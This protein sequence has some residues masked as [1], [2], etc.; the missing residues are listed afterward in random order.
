[1]FRVPF[2]SSP[3]GVDTRGAAPY[4][5][6]RPKQPTGEAPPV[7]RN[8]AQARNR[9]FAR[10][11]SEPT[12]VGER[13]ADGA[14][15]APAGAARIAGPDPEG[16][17]E[18]ARKGDPCPRPAVRLHGGDGPGG[19]LGLELG[20]TR[21]TYGQRSNN[22]FT[23]RLPSGPGGHSGLSASRCARLPGELGAG[24]FARATASQTRRPAL[25][26]FRS[27]LLYPS[28]WNGWAWRF[29]VLR[30]GHRARDHF[31]IQE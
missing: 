6:E 31:T 21:V 23:D 22:R 27:V 24:S 7:P 28:R 26:P 18:I 3:R 5:A 8:R 11:S 16:A 13:R 4:L 2:I 30:V 15:V 25:L 10:T 20:E 19:C 17:R 12:S 29:A 14:P 1:M 9:R